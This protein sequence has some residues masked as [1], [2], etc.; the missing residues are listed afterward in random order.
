MVP[1]KKILFDSF[2]DIKSEIGP[3]VIKSEPKWELEI[4][5][6]DPKTAKPETNM[7]GSDLVIANT[8][9]RKVDNCADDMKVDTSNKPND[10]VRRGRQYLTLLFNL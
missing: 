1:T 2:T 5:I 8:V 4:D 3:L 6:L 7:D 10:E 9:I